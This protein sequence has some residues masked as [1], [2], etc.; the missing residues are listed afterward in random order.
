MNF[1]ND[2]MFVP[3]NEYSIIPFLGGKHE[4]YETAINV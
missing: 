2:R 1:L 4:M 3:K